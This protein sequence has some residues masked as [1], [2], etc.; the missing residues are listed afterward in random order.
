MHDPTR[1][2]WPWRAPLLLREHDEWGEVQITHSALGREL[3]FD[4]GAL[5]GRINLQEPWVP[6]SEYA[7]T[8]SLAPALL[9]EELMSPPPS[10]ARGAQVGVLGLG[11]GNGAEFRGCT[12]LL[13][14]EGLHGAHG[15]LS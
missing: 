13:E 10:Q 12:L 9:P 1:L 15:V 8:M 4:G 3:R 5:Q 7:V 14:N 6:L 11:T 2:R